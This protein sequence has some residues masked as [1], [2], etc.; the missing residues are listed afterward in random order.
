[1]LFRTLFHP[2][3]RVILLAP[4]LLNA[5]QLKEP[6]PW[7]DWLEPDTPFFSSI[8]DARNVGN[9]F[10]SDNLTPR[11]LIINLG[12][13][14]W[15]CFDTDLLRVAAIWRGKSV[16]PEALAPKSYHPSGGKTKGGQVLLP[17]PAG[18]VWFANGIYPGWQ[19]GERLELGDPRQPAPSPEEV[20]R[21]P[22]SEE[23]GR[24]KAIRLSDQGAVLEYTC[25]NSRILEIISTSK[26]NGNVVVERHFGIGP[27]NQS[28]MLVIGMNADGGVALGQSNETRV[29]NLIEE[30][31]RWIVRVPAHEKPIQF[32]V[33]LTENGTAPSVEPRAIP[34]NAAEVRWP[35]EAITRAK[36][37]IE[38][39]PY[40][41]DDIALPLDNPW[42]RNVRPSDIQFLKDGTGV[43]PTIEGDVWLI[44]GLSELLDSV[45]WKRFATGLHEPMT[46]AI[47]DN[48]IYAFDRNGIWL[49]RDTNGNGEADIHELFSNA[50]AQTADMREFPS[51][52]RLAPNG[53]FVIAKGG[54]QA[55]TLGK[56]NGSVLR[57]S[58]DGRRSTVLGSGF[59][60]PSIGVNPRTGLVTSSDQ[61]GQYIPST[62][63]HIAQDGQFYGYLSE[64]LHEQENYPAPIAEP[65]TWI[66]HS[67]NA[68]AMSQIWTYGAK[69]G[70]LNNQLVHIGFNRPEL[71]NITLNE[72][73]P[74]LQAAVSSI[75]S[76]FQHP[77]LNG[78]V[79]PK[80]GQLYIA[81][82][83]VAGWGT[84]VDR[85][86]G[87]SRIRYTK[88]ESTLPVEIIPMKQGILL[89]F[90]IQLDRDNAINPNNYSLSNWSYRR[91]YQYG[92][93]Q[94]K[95]NGEAGVDW[96]SPSSAYLS[97]DRKKIF[98]G[99]P[100]IK[101]VMQL[102]IGW[103]LATED[104]KA[105]E[106][107]AYTTPYS[108]PNFDPINEGFGKLSVDLTPREIIETQDG[109]ISIEEGERLYKLKG[110]IACHSLT[111]SD[112]PK[113]GPS[114]SGLF[115]SERTVFADRKKETIIANED[116]LRESILDPVAKVVPQYAKGEYAMPSYAGV[117]AESQIESLVLFIK[118]LQVN[119]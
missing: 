1:M 42:K 49:L 7:A 72:R 64:G 8:L 51:T 57:I 14:C 79:N 93:G 33:T 16:T 22:L 55:T 108:L 63:L 89:G 92:S 29:A 102:R 73:S 48:Q 45:H 94:Y 61:E 101:P 112:M 119:P 47:R 53:E 56:H 38:K 36:L 32:C 117:L 103:S 86:G 97:K 109:P 62:P 85:L 77:L 24:F 52:I 107:N 58:A 60:Q 105:F 5:A 115:N 84:T 50:F 66:P 11:G 12:N 104:G 3:I 54:Q 118:S 35:K 18:N 41:V 31:S 68:S 69:M 9:A 113:V 99:I 95:A 71:F 83:Q 2:I 59:R 114:W 27:S 26:Y 110:C 19:I 10:P 67:V 46:V 106:E 82:F 75:T 80:D 25:N 20:G 37:S 91:T 13:D 30:R 34:T 6:S 4:P 78:S 87:I 100:E 65:I 40:V 111:G 44:H 17:K 21:G 70:P 23:Q 88:A 28:L 98:I 43:M 15:A 96:L 81:G 90:D 39:A 116:Y 74:R 76:D